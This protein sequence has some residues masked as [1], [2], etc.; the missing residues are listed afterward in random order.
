ME[1]EQWN[2]PLPPRLVLEIHRTQNVEGFTKARFVFNG[3]DAGTLTIPWKEWSRFVKVLNAGA[4]HTYE[5]YLT[6]VR[7]IGVAIDVAKAVVNKV[8]DLAEKIVGQAEEVPNGTED[9]VLDKEIPQGD[10][11]GKVGNTAGEFGDFAGVIP[12]EGERAGED[13][14]GPHEGAGRGEGK[15]GK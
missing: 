7:V 1:T 9:K 6:E 11:A 15:G 12:G 2:K 5:Q 8:I 14:T 13:S 10:Q 3:E 4:K